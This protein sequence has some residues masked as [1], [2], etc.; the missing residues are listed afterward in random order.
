M[1]PENFEERQKL[2]IRFILLYAGSIVLLILGFVALSSR[3][4]APV[5]KPVSTTTTDKQVDKLTTELDSTRRQV[6]RLRR[7]ML[8]KDSLIDQ[9]AMAPVPDIPDRAFEKKELARIQKEQIAIRKELLITL[10]ELVKSPDTEVVRK[11]R[12]RL[13]ALRIS[14]STVH[15]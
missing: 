14:A 4:P 1:K 9:L 12:E 2:M 3:E 8:I 5:A 15:D 11:A 10:D 7:E 6:W 13:I